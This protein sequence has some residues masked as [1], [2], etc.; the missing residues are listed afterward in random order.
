MKHVLVH[1]SLSASLLHSMRPC[2]GLHVR[3]TG[4]WDGV[5]SEEILFF[6]G[7]VF[8]GVVVETLTPDHY[9][10]KCM[11]KKPRVIVCFSPFF[12]FVFF[13]F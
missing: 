1:L 6:L 12:L 11:E 9:F 10:A 4:Y 3:L 8:S 13:F 7:S 5:I 2:N